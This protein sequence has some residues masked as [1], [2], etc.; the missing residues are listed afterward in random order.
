MIR[1]LRVDS[2]R[3]QNEID[4]LATYSDVPAPNVT[5]ILFTPI[6][7]QARQ[8]IRDLM[9]EAGLTIHEDA[10]GNI[11]GRWDG[12]D[13]DLPAV[14]TGSHIDA[15]PYSGRFDGVV[16]VL[17]GIEAIRALRKTGFIPRRS[18][19]VIMFTAEEP[20]RFGI[21]CLGS[22]AM[23]GNLTPQRLRDLRDDA[24]TPFETVRQEAG[25]TDSLDAVQLKQGHYHAF[26]EL[27][28]EQGSR[29]EKA[30]L[31]LG[32]VTAIAA[33]AT[34]RVVLHGDGG[35]AGTVLMPD[36][37]DALP[38]V[39]EIILAVE[40]SAR[41]STSPDAVATVGLCD[42][43]PNA[44]NS[45]P[46]RVML[47]ID[48]RDID[49]KSR[50]GMVER[51]KQAVDNVCDRRGLKAE[52]EILNADAPCQS[53]EAI[54]N[55]LTANA[56]TL[57][58]AYQTMVSRA[59]HDTLF[60]AEICPTSMIFVPS[61]NGYSHRPEEYTSPE[62]IARGVELLAYTLADLAR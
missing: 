41:D 6:E 59:Y 42:V 1:N 45:I 32:I 27:H 5:R 14:S 25:Y 50:D 20:T 29:L 26:V 62:D 16:G 22:R 33:P 49:L 3:L 38:A 58:Y 44:V 17:G 37:H 60:M 15:I 4:E 7:L 61:E 46:S 56:D 28:I 40:K 13:S 53:G 47:E 30:Q 2:T 23:V 12:T 48:I 11:F 8:Y 39:A 21:G 57:G 36:R 9:S 34:L 55:S 19:E 43:Y 52:V 51:V 24:D 31:P 35:H 18:L 10:V 54:I